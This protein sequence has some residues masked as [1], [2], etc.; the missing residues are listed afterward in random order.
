VPALGPLPP[1]RDL[2]VPVPGSTT[3]REVL[4]RAIGRLLRELRP[5]LRAH[6]AAAPRDAAAIDRVLATLLR[7]R[8]GPL[9]S[10]LRRPHVA[11]LVRTLRATPRSHGAALAAELRAT[12]AFDLAHLGALPGALTLGDLP[13]RI[14]SLTTRSV[15]RVPPGVRELAFAPGAPP[16]LPLDGQPFRDIEGDIVLALADNNPLAMHEAHPDKHGNAVDLGGRPVEAWLEAL[17]GA[18]AIVAAYLPELREEMRPYVQAIVPV[19]HFVDRHL[20]ASYREAIGLMYLSL[21]PSEMTMVEALVH[22]YQHS[23]LNALFELDDVLDDAHEP[24]YASPVRPDPRPLAGVL[25]A[26]HAFVPVALLYRR[27]QQAGDARAAAPDFDRRRRE[28]ERINR[29]G[30]EVLLAHARPTAVGRGLL[31][32]IERVLA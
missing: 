8:P 17:R 19:G 1:P 18:L 4:S 21:H 7:D 6:A 22:E 2:T 25:L 32:E 10:L 28:I 5:L 26:V 13:P 16:A 12:L 24:L 14:V 15:A 27:M 29:E 30:A 20:S 11:A 31:G 3:A 23:K 9:A